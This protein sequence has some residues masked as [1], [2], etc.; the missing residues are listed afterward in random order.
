MPNFARI[1]FTIPNE[2][3]DK[4]SQQSPDIYLDVFGS[5]RGRDH[6]KIGDWMRIA[7]GTTVER[8]KEES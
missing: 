5:V 1:V 4:M 2:I 7:P 8:Y 3:A 6:Q